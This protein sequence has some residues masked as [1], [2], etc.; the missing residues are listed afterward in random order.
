MWQNAANRSNVV[1]DLISISEHS[2]EI[3]SLKLGNYV[4]KV[5]FSFLNFAKL[6]CPIRKIMLI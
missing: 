1:M 4:S 5:H 3:K 2:L 6:L